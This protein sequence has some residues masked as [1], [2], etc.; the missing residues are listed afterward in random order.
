MRYGLAH[1]T[2]SF[3]HVSEEVVQQ[4]LAF[5]SSQLVHESDK[6]GSNSNHMGSMEDKRIVFSTFTF[7]K[8]RVKN[9]WCEHL[10]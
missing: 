6:N 9:R 3:V 10:D 4:C 2:K 7:M 5:Y 8:T 1:G